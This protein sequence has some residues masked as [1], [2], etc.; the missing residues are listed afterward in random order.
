MCDIY[1]SLYGLTEP[2]SACGDVLRKYGK[3]LFF[4][5]SHYNKGGADG[6]VSSVTLA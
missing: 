6:G 5:F 3:F 2:C 4:L 1:C